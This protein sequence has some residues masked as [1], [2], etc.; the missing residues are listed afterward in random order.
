MAGMQEQLILAPKALLYCMWP[1]QPIHSSLIPPWACLQGC[2]Q[3]FPFLSRQSTDDD[4]RPSLPPSLK[5]SVGGSARCRCLPM[6][7]SATH[8]QCSV[9]GRGKHA[10]PHISRNFYLRL[11]TLARSPSRWLVGWLVQ[12]AKASMLPFPSHPSVAAQ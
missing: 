9:R 10:A 4:D 6:C 2:M 12:E 8:H 1:C 5:R 7:C 11:L 3:P